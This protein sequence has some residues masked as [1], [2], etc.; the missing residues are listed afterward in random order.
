MDDQY[1]GPG[2]M[3]FQLTPLSSESQTSPPLGAATNLYPSAEEA[4]E[5][6]VWLGALVF[7]QLA[8][9]L[10]E[11]QI[12]ALQAASRIEPSSEEATPAKL[13]PGTTVDVP[14]TPQFVETYT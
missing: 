14:E 13:K 10:V 12:E 8:P 7:I 3:A 6:Q 5:D 2:P 9:K 11:M 4:T 1:D